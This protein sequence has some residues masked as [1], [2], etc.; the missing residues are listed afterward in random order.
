VPISSDSTVASPA[1][2]FSLMTTRVLIQPNSASAVGVYIS[3][4]QLAQGGQLG[5]GTTGFTVMYRG[6]VQKW[7]IVGTTGGPIIDPHPITPD[8]PAPA[9]APRPTPPRLVWGWADDTP[10][11]SLS[12]VFR[13]SLS[14][15]GLASV[16]PVGT[17]IV[18]DAAAALEAVSA[19]AT[20]ASAPVSKPGD[21]TVDAA[22]NTVAIALS[23]DPNSA[24]TLARVRASVRAGLTGIAMKLGAITSSGVPVRN[25]LPVVRAA[26]ALP[27]PPAPDPV[28]AAGN[29]CDPDNIS[30]A[31]AASATAQQLVC[32]LTNQTTQVQVPGSFQNALMGDVILSPGGD[33]GDQVIAALLRALSPPQ[34]YSHSGLMTENYV[35]ITHCTAAASRLS[36]NT[37]GP[38]GVGGI[39]PDV[40][41]YAWPG[42]ITQTIDVAITGEWWIDPKGRKYYIGGFTPESLGITTNEEF[43]LI[44]PLVVKP[45]PANE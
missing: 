6:A 10:P 4:G 15:S 11:V 42:S 30:D 35:Q 27:G 3:L 44:P 32:Q 9:P 7:Q 19:V 16:A 8:S 37:V 21:Q 45:L 22:T 23:G 17:S 26:P 41:E 25:A 33:G 38:S 18:F 12:W 20:D 31:D 2:V 24:A 13:I 14:D 36:D 1:P 29:I 34:Y 5:P 43:I 39:Q 28:V 40:L